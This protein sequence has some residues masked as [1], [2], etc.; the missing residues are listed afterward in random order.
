MDEALE[1]FGRGSHIAAMLPDEQPT[2]EQIAVFR[3]MTPDQKYKAARQ[4]YWTVRKHKAAYLRSLH[5]EWSEERLQ[6][7]V[8]TIFLRARS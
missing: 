8:R 5:P 1:G 2:P 7:E 3:A 6:D 4:L